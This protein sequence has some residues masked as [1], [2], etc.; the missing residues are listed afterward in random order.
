[1]D[2]KCH[3]VTSIGAICEPGGCCVLE[4]PRGADHEGESMTERVDMP[5]CTSVL[6]GIPNNQKQFAQC[7]QLSQTILRTFPS[8]VT[9]KG[10]VMCS[11]D[12]AAASGPFETVHDVWH[13]L[14]NM[15]VVKHPS[16]QVGCKY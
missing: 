7:V 11:G 13:C 16:S 3:K 5:T 8:N 6:D 15:H 1:M 12:V 14:W 10:H 9:I 4:V 2:S